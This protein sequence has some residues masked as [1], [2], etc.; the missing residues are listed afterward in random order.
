MVGAMREES[1]EEVTVTVFPPMPG[2]GIV[3]DEPVIEDDESC[4][5]A[6]LTVL[7][8]DPSADSESAVVSFDSKDPI[9]RINQMLSEAKE[10]HGDSLCIRVADYDTS[11][12]L[13]DAIEWLN[14]ALRGSGDNTV[15]D[16]QSFSMFIGSSAPIITINNRLSFVGTV[17]TKDLLLGRISAALRSVRS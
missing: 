4:G 5:D 17:P 7:T 1:V 12:S 13:D 2:I 15:L 14:S 9:V 6:S 3:E 8:I 11:E 10:T 16:S